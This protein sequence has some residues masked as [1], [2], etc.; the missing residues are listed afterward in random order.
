MSNVILINPKYSHNVGGALR[1][2]HLFGVEGLYWTG[3]R[4]QAP[5]EGLPK[6][7]RRL[8]REERMKEYRNVDFRRIES[9]EQEVTERLAGL[10]QSVGF[11]P[12]AIE[13]RE[14]AESL[15][16]F[17]HPLDALYVFGPEDGTLGRGTLSWCH[18]F[19][20]IPTLPDGPLNLAA[21]V[22]VVL[23]D[24][25]AKESGCVLAKEISEAQR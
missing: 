16:E 22:N 15:P 4:V 20:T 23:Y 9:W 6:R 19:V 18:R 8:P 17:V 11:T 7:G 2:C 21:A 10:P 5:T 1:A 3:D 25:L 14:N 24:R 13:R 12:V